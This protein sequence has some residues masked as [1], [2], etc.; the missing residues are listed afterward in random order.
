MPT[1]F[2]CLAIHRGS[3]GILMGFNFQGK[4]YLVLWDNY[5]DRAIAPWIPLND[6]L[7]SSVK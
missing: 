5:S 1:G 7:I 2:D 3:N 4:G 6:R